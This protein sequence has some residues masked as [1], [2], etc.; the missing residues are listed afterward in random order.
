MLRAVAFHNP[1][2]H[3][4]LRRVLA[5]WRDGTVDV[6]TFRAA[7]SNLTDLG[8]ITHPRFDEH[9]FLTEEGWDQLGAET[10]LE[11]EETWST[12]LY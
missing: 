1:I 5:D 8:L 12:V 7:R 3:L 11:A 10:P 4:K 6:E 2:D 9:Y